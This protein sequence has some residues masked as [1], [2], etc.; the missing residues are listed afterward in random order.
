MV[1]VLD[2]SVISPADATST[3]D[4]AVSEVTCMAQHHEVL[5]C[6]KTNSIPQ[7]QL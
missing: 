1:I 7:E 2:F 4:A 5:P 6:R 3:A